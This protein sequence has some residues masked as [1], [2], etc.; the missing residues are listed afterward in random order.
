MVLGGA[1]LLLASCGAITDISDYVVGDLDASL[2]EKGAR[3]G[4]SDGGDGDDDDDADP[5]GSQDDRDASADVGA[6]LDAE[7]DAQVGGCRSTPFT[8]ARSITAESAFSGSWSNP[9]FAKSADGNTADYAFSLKNVASASLL[10]RDF[11]FTVPSNATITGVT[12]RITRSAN[13]S[14]I[15]DAIVSLLDGDDATGDNL[16]ASSLGWSATL[17]AKTYGGDQELWGRSFSPSFV[18]SDTFGV[19]VSMVVSTL[20]GVPTTPVA[21]IDEVAVSIAYCE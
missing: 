4:K 20:D 12:V 8:S 21:R 11:G 19:G 15:K 9:E 3:G 18:D 6:T 1:A 13:F 10:L 5:S 16:A 7:S 17:Q 14:Y 2:D